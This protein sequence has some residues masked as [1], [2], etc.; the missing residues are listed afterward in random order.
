MKLPTSLLL[1][2]GTAL[3][4]PVAADQIINLSFH[5]EMTGKTYPFEVTVHGR[6]I[7]PGP[8]PSPAPASSA[9]LAP[10]SQ[11]VYCNIYTGDTLLAH[12]N[13]THNYSTLGQRI[14]LSQIMVE[15]GM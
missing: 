4:A 3:A 5:D 13:S 15:C 12:L 6:K 7:N 9:Q 11:T 2:F 8:I 1:L 14:D 10:F